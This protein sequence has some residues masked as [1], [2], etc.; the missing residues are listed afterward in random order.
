MT[1]EYR[2]LS[3]VYTAETL[4]AKLCEL[5]Q[6]GFKLVSVTESFDQEGSS[7]GDT[8]YLMREVSSNP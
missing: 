7:T 1:Y 6:Q 2:V 3:G 4:E 5:G 8:L